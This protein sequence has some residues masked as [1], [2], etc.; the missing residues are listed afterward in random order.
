MAGEQPMN[1]APSGLHPSYP[2]RTA[3]LDLRPHTMADLDD[4]YAFHSRPDVVRYVP[5][6][7]RDR[8]QTRA[9]LELK[10]GQGLLTEP[11]QWLV[12][13]MELRETHTVIGEVLLKWASATNHQGEIGFAMHTDYH[14]QG[15]AREAAIEILKLGFIELGLRRIAG[16]VVLGNRASEQLL[17]R[18]G[19][20]LEGTLRDAL[21]WKG[22]WADERIFAMTGEEYRASSLGS[23]MSP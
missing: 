11:G 16:H 18:L 21:L 1:D 8:E 17:T 22:S 7:V 23:P 12:L 15:L 19:M 6:P 2:I 20:R 9:A 5:W 10:L 14:G 4:L 3:R 13:A